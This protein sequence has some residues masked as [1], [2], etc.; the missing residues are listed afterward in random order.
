MHDIETFQFLDKY[1]RFI[2]EKGRRETWDEAVDRTVGWF[3]SKFGALL[4]PDDW[5]TIDRAQ[6]EE[7]ASFS[8]RAVQMAGR[9]ADRCNVCIY[10]CAAVG[11]SS[12]DDL[13]D[14]L[15]ILM[16]GTGCAFSVE[17]Y[18]TDKMPVIA[19]ALSRE[20]LEHYVV[21]S[22]EGWC[23]ALAA[24]LSAWFNGREINFDTT[25]VRPEGARLAT[26]GGFASGP[27]PLVAMLGY[28]RDIVT[29][30]SGRRLRP[31]EVHK[32]ACKIG[33]VVQVGGVRRAAMLSLSDLDD[34]EM[35][36]AKSGEFWKTSPELA[37][38]NNSAVYQDDLD[39]EMF[40]REWDN[41]RTSGTGERGIFNRNSAVSTAPRRQTV[42]F[43]TNPCGEI[44]LRSR[45]FCNLSIAIVRPG[46]SRQVLRSKVRT[47]AIMGTLQ[48]ACTDFRYIHPGWKA[49]S[50]EEA[51]LGVDLLGALDNAHL[52][53]EGFL[54]EL[55][56]LVVATNAQYSAKL[57][58]AQACA[59]TC[60]KPGGN[61]GERYG[62]GNSL[63]GWYAPYYKRRVRVDTTS[64]MYLFLQDQGVPVEM[65]PVSG[66]AVFTFYKAA[67]PGARLRGDM[68]ALDVLNWWKKLK[69][70]WTEH[71]PSVTVPVRPHEWNDVN[72]WLVANWGIVGGLSFLPY[73]GGVY[74]LAPFEEIGEQEYLD[75]V[76]SFPT[77]EWS[78]FGDYE[79]LDTTTVGQ[80]MACL[81]GACLIN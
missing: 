70:N 75:A 74:P 30:A 3:R 42:R 31:V 9:P 20:A 8:M 54:A 6:R 34:A 64:P 23:D 25:G 49:N 59:T 78:Q 13:V 18:Y 10:N 44:L 19:P 63:T 52:Q 21:D 53:D 14:I 32:I 26:K 47:A 7:A 36:V 80:E 15:Y 12:I 66:K 79:E 81:G 51:L 41:L 2:E 37:M 1:A 16:Q 5:N 33:E 46:D 73:D 72:N 4:S 55:K 39:L 77:I 58:I 27:A 11:I 62:T 57:G 56:G 45:Q 69:T 61:S 43:L 50:R 76:A 71:N 35:M 40:A 17:R 22:T 67:P 38:A 60:I 28:I 29:G 24:G 48:A 65:D 68:T